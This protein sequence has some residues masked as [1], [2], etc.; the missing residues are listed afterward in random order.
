MPMRK[1]EAQKFVRRRHPEWTEHW[2]TWR[3][4]A[5]GLEGGDRYRFADYTIAPDADAG[6]VRRL[7]PFASAT[8]WNTRGRAAGPVA[9]GSADPATG[10]IAPFNFGDA[11]DRNLIPHSAEMG[12]NGIDLYLL[13]LARTPPPTDLARAIESHLSKVFAKDPDRK[14]PAEVE[15]WWKDVDGC[16]TPIRRWMEDEVGPLLLALGQ[17][18]I[19]V[20]HPAPPAGMADKIRTKRDLIDMG[21]TGAVASII[22]PENVVWWSLDHRRRYR[23]VL[24]LDRP[25]DGDGPVY[26][27]WHAK[28]VDCY[29]PEGQPVPER[30]REYGY[31][32]PPIRR[33]FDRRKPRC[34]NVGKS[35]YEGI[36]ATQTAAY[37]VQSE[38]ELANVLQAHPQLQGPG[39][40]LADGEVPMGP[41]NVLP[42]TPIKNQTGQT[43]GYQPWQF[44]DPPQGAHEALRQSILDY[45]ERIDRDAAL[46]KPAGYSGGATVSQSGV[47]KAYD[48]QDGDAIL[49]RVAEVLE[50][51]EMAAA[52]LAL[53][54]LS[55][56]PATPERL[57]TV[58]VEYP[59]DY[60]LWTAQDV[61]DAL[62]AVQTGAAQ[63]GALP[64]TEAA[65]LKRLVSVSLVGAAEDDI[66][67]F[68]DEIDAFFEARAARPAPTSDPATDPAEADASDPSMQAP[69]GPTVAGQTG[70]VQK[71]ALNGAQV[72][73][74]SELVAAVGTGALPKPSAKA[75]I[76]ASFPTLESSLVDS[77][78]DPIEVR[79]PEPSPA[80]FRPR[81]QPQVT[82]DAP[83]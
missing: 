67:R 59:K 58:E 64:E 77:I 4:I 76:V 11:V 31:G 82:P 33:V 63:A 25:D 60:D 78:V 69:A 7:S 15:S 17:I 1:V 23:E 14:G 71:T 2:R 54:A 24:T 22:L 49:C 46:A 34:R 19:C 38:R 68:H 35:R 52:E 39:D 10:L 5:D 26:L 66:K 75:I 27:H 50:C 61:A 70:D 42:M 30:S 40:S 41:G 18:D 81:P 13:R 53:A 73:A 57:A 37:N 20:D 74:L 51:A 36:A 56:R 3:R 12:P 65:L 9:V 44:L 29:T 55:G 32:A 83:E 79:P 48:K 28:G 72:Q 45:A 6:P 62:Q 16:G 47:S 43:S 21:L 8:P 80:M